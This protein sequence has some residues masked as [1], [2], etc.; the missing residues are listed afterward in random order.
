MDY[1]Y[2]V[3]NFFETDEGREKM[4]YKYQLEKKKKVEGQETCFVQQQCKHKDKQNAI[5]V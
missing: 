4:K 1:Q 2:F 3:E 5:V